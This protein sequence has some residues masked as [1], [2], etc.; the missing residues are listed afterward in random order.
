[1]GRHFV[2][3]SAFVLVTGLVLQS[4][5]GSQGIE[6]ELKMVPGTYMLHIHVEP[7]LGSDLIAFFIEDY[8]HLALAESLLDEGPLGISVVSIDITTLI[9]Q[10]MILSKAA[11]RTLV[12]NNAVDILDIHP[13]TLESRIDFVTD[14]GRI[15]G[16]VAERDGWTC[17]Y[18]GT[19][20]SIVIRQWLELEESSSMIADSAL[21]AVVS[22]GYDLSI[23][24]SG[25][26]IGFVSLLPLDRYIAGWDR[27]REAITT[28]RPM[29]MS[30]NLAYQDSSH[31]ISI[32]AVV[33]REDG[34]ISRIK[35]EIE[36]S[37]LSTSDVEP[38]LREW[39]EGNLR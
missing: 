9:P 22:D 6:D 36:D 31:A 2:A 32:S 12:V 37:R 29:A 33:A 1:M 16:S 38:I 5:G 28:V 20:P 24:I 25:N 7:E 26:L 3:L 18:L 14:N 30:L 8:P 27:I 13:D 19:A 23:L 21:L 11:D 34:A 17:V 15:R 39:I 10:L 35:L 4:C